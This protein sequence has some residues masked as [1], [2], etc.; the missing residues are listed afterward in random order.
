MTVDWSLAKEKKNSLPCFHACPKLC[1]PSLRMNTGPSTAVGSHEARG[2]QW[3][4]PQESPTHGE[5]EH[6]VLL[7]RRQ[8]QQA[9]YN[10]SSRSRSSRSRSRSRSRSTTEEDHHAS[11]RQKLCTGRRR[12]LS[13]GARGHPS[14]PFPSCPFSPSSSSAPTPN[15]AEQQEA[16]P[17]RGG[18]CS[19]HSSSD[20]RRATTAGAA[21]GGR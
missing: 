18:R 12:A 6:Y 13:R 16:A 1:H 17:L 3:W 8:G 15:P 10:S 5:R 7:R 21:G 19:S 2:Q 14:C 4:W 11:Q 20:N 9:R